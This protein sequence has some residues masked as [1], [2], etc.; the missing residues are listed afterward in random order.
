[1]SR[2]IRK[3]MIQL[4]Q[5]ICRCRSSVDVI[6]NIQLLILLK[7]YALELDAPLKV[8]SSVIRNQKTHCKQNGFI[9]NVDKKTRKSKRVSKRSNWKTEEGKLERR[10]WIKEHISQIDQIQT[11]WAWFDL[12]QI[13]G[14]WKMYMEFHLLSA[15]NYMFR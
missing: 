1:M 13:F 5:R 14:W 6:T 10:H 12:Y 3:I 2:L 11:R 7:I 4:K 15:W 8:L 9:L